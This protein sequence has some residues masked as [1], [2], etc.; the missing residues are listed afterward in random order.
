MKR[1]AL[2][3]CFRL[4]CVPSL[5]VLCVSVL[6]SPGDQPCRSG[7]QPGARPGPYAAVV[8]TGPER[9]RS[10]CYICETADRPAVIIFA[11]SLN[12]PLGKLAGEID[13][14]LA[15][16]KA[17]GLRGWVTFLHADQ[18]SFDPKVVDWGQRHAL[19]NLPLAIFEDAGGPPSY[20][21][22]ADADVTVL[23]SVRQRVVANFAFRAGEL[24]DATVAEILRALP[25]ILNTKG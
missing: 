10:H 23:L 25:R 21:L 7:L 18:P 15:R 11:R 17:A 19:R 12:E 16:H 9:G 2:S 24:N 6:R 20:R 14:A 5:C 4:L 3:S 13:R 1:A 22:A 8:S